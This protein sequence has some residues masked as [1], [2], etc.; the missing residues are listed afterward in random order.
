[1]A[2]SGS[3]TSDGLA[4]VFEEGKKKKSQHYR[5]KNVNLV[6]PGNPPATEAAASLRACPSAA[7]RDGSSVF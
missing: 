1:M 7:G 3:A 6:L 2:N 5:C 4:V